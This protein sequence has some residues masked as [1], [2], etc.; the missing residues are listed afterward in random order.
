MSTKKMPSY[1]FRKAQQRIQAAKSLALHKEE[2]SALNEANTELNEIARKESTFRPFK[3]RKRVIHE[4]QLEKQNAIK[5]FI[6]ETAG[7]V[8]YGSLPLEDT[9]KVDYKDKIQEKIIDR[10]NTVVDNHEMLSH[11]PIKADY[12]QVNNDTDPTLFM[13]KLG[14]CRYLASMSN[15]NEN[16]DYAR[17]MMIDLLNISDSQLGNDANAVISKLQENFITQATK[18][19]SEKVVAALAEE[20]EKSNINEYLT[21]AADSK[22]F[23]T[24]NKELIRKSKKNSVFQEVYKT[25]LQEHS[26]LLTEGVDQDKKDLLMAEAILEYTLLET[27]N[28]LNLETIDPD[29]FIKDQ[30]QKRYQ[31]KL[32]T[33]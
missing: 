33:L 32:S 23:K 18:L 11:F 24:A 14:E 4:K 9:F 10:F 25:V 3:S 6:L 22:Y 15:R 17:A 16:T 30:I 19:V 27:M 12:N 21:E 31:M 26:Y 28:T 29:Q 20:A 5:E 13:K 7:H 1:T 2:Q 8:F